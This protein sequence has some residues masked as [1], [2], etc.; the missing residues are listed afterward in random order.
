[1]RNQPCLTEQCSPGSGMFHLESFV[2]RRVRNGV[3]FRQGR[4]R[5]PAAEFFL[6]QVG[7]M[8]LFERIPLGDQQAPEQKL[9]VVRNRMIFRQNLVQSVRKPFPAQFGK[10]RIPGRRPGLPQCFALTGDQLFHPVAQ[11]PVVGAVIAVHHRLQQKTVLLQLVGEPLHLAFP[12]LPVPSHAKRN[13][14][15][16][17]LIEIL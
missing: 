2:T 15:S 16:P 7:P 1:M 6:Q 14:L 12:H 11:G 3:V 5:I 17:G 4:R 10:A 13:Q 8:C 9:V